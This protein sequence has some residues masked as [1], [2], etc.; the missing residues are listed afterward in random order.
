MSKP[1]LIEIGFEE[2]PAIPLLKELQNISTKFHNAIKSKG[3]HQ[4]FEFFYTP[5]RFVFFCDNMPG[6]GADEEV[7]FFGPPV[8]VAFKDSTPTKAYDSFLSKNSLAQ[9]DVKT[10]QKDGKECL[11]ASKT[12]TGAMLSDVI[13]SVLND[14]LGSLVFG[15]SMLWGSRSDGF[16]RPIRWLVVMHGDEVL[17]AV[18]YDV[19]SSNSTFG[20]RQHS[21]EPLSIANAKSL[22]SVLSSSGVEMMQ[23]VRK[24]LVLEQIDFLE[25]QHLVSVEVDSALLAE[26][27]AIT[28]NPTVLLGYYEPEFLQVAPEIII[29][30][31]KENQRYFPVFKDGKLYNAFVVVS[32]A[33][34]DDFTSVVKGNERV[35]KARLSDALFFWNNDLSK[36]LTPELL[37]NI[38]FVNGLGSVYDKS[39]REAEIA[40]GLGKLWGLK[41]LEDI[42]SAMHLS[43]ADL[44]TEA[45][46]EFGELQGVMGRYYAKNDGYSSEIAT[47]IEEHYLPKGE[48]SSL[49]S[50]LFSATCAIASKLDSIMALFSIGMIPTGSKDPLALR[51][52]AYGI[53]RVVLEFNLNFSI[54]QVV[55]QFSSLYKTFDL[56][57]VEEFMLDRVYQLF[58]LINPS[59]VKAVIDSGERDILALAEKIEALDVVSKREGFR[60]NFS[61]FK[62][63][64][65][66]SKDVIVSE[67]SVVRI[68]LFENEHEKKLYDKFS[69]IG[70]AGSYFDTLNSLFG[71]KSELDAFFENCM[72][73]AED[74]KVRDNRKT[75]VGLIYASFR[76]IA[77]I[78]EIAF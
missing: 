62:R 44:V 4:Q 23:D 55:L 8:A 67:S 53:V 71:L 68:E 69:S 25:K 41:N 46:G 77:D 43:K 63:V 31:M 72:V 19:A 21:F 5:R 37:K 14:F 20:H 54:R 66:I 45:V 9:E 64:A 74:L 51:R 32:N 22:P 61:T 16:I 29:T 13:E 39:M 24:N 59:I 49:P 60:E 1:L 47:A 28:E 56:S 57:T 48:D 6:V 18:V 26:V 17:P 30:S 36:R 15:K 70:D 75:L 42:K 52:A 7:E 65:N 11:Y 38:V 2:L 35:L 73:N 34:C 3:F 58:T 50:S 10:A 27:V 40:E 33:K 12:K 76:K 78:K